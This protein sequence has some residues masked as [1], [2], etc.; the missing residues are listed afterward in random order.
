MSDER[1]YDGLRD[2][3]AVIGSIREAQ[4]R[5]A[6]PRFVPGSP[7]FGQRPPPPPPRPPPPAKPDPRIVLGFAPGAKVTLEEVKKRHRELARK[8]HPDHGGTTARM[9]EINQAVDELLA[10]M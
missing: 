8:H 1:V 5:G 4:Q 9:T 10:S 6:L 2:A 3:A 7:G